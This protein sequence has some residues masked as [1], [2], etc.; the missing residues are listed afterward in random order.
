M[1]TAT[2]ET[3]RWG[4]DLAAAWYDRNGYRLLAR[5]WRCPAGEVDLIV[6]RGR[7]VVVCEVKARRTDAFGPAAAAVG[8]VKQQ[9]LRRLAAAWLATTR[10]S[11]ASRS[12]S[13]SSPSPATTSTS[14]PARSSSRATRPHDQRQ[15]D[16]DGGD[17]EHVVGRSGPEL[18]VRVEAHGRQYRPRHDL[19][20]AAGRSCRRDR[21]RH[22]EPPG[23][24]ERRQR[25]DV[26]RAARRLPRGRRQ[27]R[28]PRARAHGR[29][30]ATSAP[31]P[32]SPATG[33]GAARTAWRTCATSATSPLALHR[34][35]Q[36]TIAKVRGV[37][38]GA[39]MNMALLCDLVVA[40]DTARF[41]E[42]FARR[43]LTIDFGGSWVLPRRVGLHRAK[44]LALLAD[45]IDAAE[46][47]R[48]G[49]VNRVVP[50]AELDA[51]VDELGRP[52][53]PPARRSPSPSP[54]GCSTTPSGARWSRRS[55]T[56]ARRRRSTS[57]PRTPPRRCAAFLE[58]RDPTFQG[59]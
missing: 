48:I 30:R 29:R 56:R 12:A 58:K 55:T 4:E 14:S 50:D 33:S 5:N 18:P 54:S 40:G 44:E 49:L 28:R 52:A 3:G 47:D 39:G 8:P 17:D 19:R 59:R 2:L 32:T 24:Q 35:P 27:R 23:T 10:A 11:A 22:A 26:G 34:L 21:H 7:L 9:R 13:T 1:S 43:G 45:I 57:R 53:S 38:A 37:A 42:I 31:A 15:G 16:D 20:D 36:P 46:A 6:R 51:F 41:S 25:R